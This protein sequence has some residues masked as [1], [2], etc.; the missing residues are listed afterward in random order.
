MNPLLHCCCFE[1]RGGGGLTVHYIVDIT[2]GLQFMYY[3]LQLLQKA[4]VQILTD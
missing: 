3:M 1:G 2:A 4:L